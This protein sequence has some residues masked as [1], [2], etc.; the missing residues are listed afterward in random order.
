MI[1]KRLWGFLGAAA[2]QS[3]NW[4]V[5]L[6]FLVHVYPELQ[7]I[8]FLILRY[9]TMHLLVSSIERFLY[10]TTLWS[11]SSQWEAS[12]KKLNFRLARKYISVKLD[13]SWAK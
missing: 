1:C 9:M 10:H 5:V 3:W 4:N 13:F 8:T 11:S 12:E 7:W 2:K 6:G